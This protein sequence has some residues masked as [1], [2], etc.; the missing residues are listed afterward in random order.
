MCCGLTV[1][2][3]RGSMGWTKGI[4]TCRRE[5]LAEGGAMKGAERQTRWRGCNKA[6]GCYCS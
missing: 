1:E 6:Q 3:E 2:L 5:R 4:G